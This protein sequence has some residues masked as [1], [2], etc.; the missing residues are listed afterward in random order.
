[1]VY[2]AHKIILIKAMN[3]SQ[4]MVIAK[5]RVGVVYSDLY[6]PSLRVLSARG[7]G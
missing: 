3:I 2:L 6:W 5:T 7:C 1:M 4:I